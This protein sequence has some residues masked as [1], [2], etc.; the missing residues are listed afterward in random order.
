[1][2]GVTA[3]GLAILSAVLRQDPKFQHA[4]GEIHLWCANPD[5]ISAEDARAYTS[6]LSGDECAYLEGMHLAS[7]RHR[8]L[9]T[10]ALAR[11]VL[12]GYLGST[13]SEVQL[14]REGH[15]KPR[16]AG[17]NGQRNSLT[18]SI[19]HANA[20]VIMGVGWVHSLGVDV[21]QVSRPAHGRVARLHF[22][23][24][25]QAAFQHL[26]PD[27][28]SKR[29]WALWTLRE[30][31]FKALGIGLSGPLNAYGFDL[32]APGS[33]IPRFDPGSLR[34]VAA[35]CDAEGSSL[36]W[37]FWQLHLPANNL[38]SV[39][40]PVPLQHP[41]VSTFKVWETVPLAASHEIAHTVLRRSHVES[42]PY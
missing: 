4:L 31:Y 17:F 23:R 9:V 7:H 38:V 34:P 6:L 2:G 25:E 29:F 42:I 20:L 30:S 8:Y 12:S 13:P 41:P 39:C 36:D 21:E 18:F 32:D 28:R 19:S 26:P 40:A 10:R 37:R 11:D 24:W 1:M 35:E 22:S 5:W 14:T 15:G 27:E 3:T 16:L 33:I